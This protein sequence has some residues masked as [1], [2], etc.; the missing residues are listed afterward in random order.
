[1]KIHLAC[2]R[3]ILDGWTNCDLEKHPKAAREPD[4]FCDVSK[5]PLDDGVADELLSVH[6]LEHFYHW[7]VPGVLA[8]WHRLLKVGGKLVIEMP[9]IRKAALNLLD[10][11]TDQMAMWPIY[12]D[13]TLKNPLMCHKW[14]WSYKTLLP[15]LMAA[16]FEAIVERPTEWHGRKHNRDFRV[17]AFK[18]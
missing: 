8:E 12:G 15:V 7:E 6:I 17:E 14:G 9:D 10:G 1:M 16:G 2:G 13:Q 3:H 11:G 5:V 4:I 18:C